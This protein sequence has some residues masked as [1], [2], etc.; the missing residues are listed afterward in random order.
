M[1]QRRG[2]PRV[3]ARAS[4]AKA[5]PG[6]GPLSFPRGHR[7]YPSRCRLWPEPR[8]RTGKLERELSAVVQVASGAAGT[9]RNDVSANTQ[10]PCGRDP[11][12][13][14]SSTT[15][16]LN[17]GLWVQEDLNPSPRLG[18][19]DM[20]MAGVAPRP[21]RGLGVPCSRRPTGPGLARCLPC[22]SGGG[23]RGRGGCPSV[24]KN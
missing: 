15:T 14:L 2:R 21:T 12:L 8:T 13:A 7:Q 9:D 20:V 24:F 4:T 23:W 17:G 22:S 3:G 6:H 1:G 16:A 18:G 11:D 19:S 10:R 5:H